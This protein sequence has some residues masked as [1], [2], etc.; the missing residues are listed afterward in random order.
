[1]T[2]TIQRLVDGPSDPKATLVLAHGAGAGMDSPFMAA[3]AGGLADRGWRVVRFN[4]PYMVRSALTGKQAA[5]DR[6]PTLVVAFQDEIQAAAQE[7]P[8]LLIGGKSMGGRIASLVLDQA[9]IDHQVRGCICLGYPFHPPGQPQKLRT[10]H[11]RELRTPCLILQGER[12]SFGRRE[13]VD[14]YD[15]SSALEVQWLPSGDHSFKPTK[16]SGLTL[17]DNLASAVERMD[18]WFDQEALATSTV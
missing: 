18:R 13:E 17:E 5:P 15:L 9:A 1:M 16:A 11:L 7:Q 3:I 8:P 10:E 4:F 12:D 14:G 2:A 6:L